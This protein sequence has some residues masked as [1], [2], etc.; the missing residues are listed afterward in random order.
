M[1]L[2]TFILFLISVKAEP[3]IGILSV[4]Q[5]EPKQKDLFGFYPKSFCINYGFDIKILLDDSNIPEIFGKDLSGRD[6]G[7]V[8]FPISSI[9]PSDTQLCFP[10][11]EEIGYNFRLKAN[12]I[13]NFKLKF[14]EFLD[15][16]L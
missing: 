8:I 15:T 3:F 16:F 12:G 2:A 10:Y 4:D 7:R 14:F 1:K 11:N 5:L 6:I 9:N 13:L